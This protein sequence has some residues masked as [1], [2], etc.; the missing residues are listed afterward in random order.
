MKKQFAVLALTAAMMSASAASYASTIMLNWTLNDNGTNVTVGEL[1]TGGS[2]AILQINPTSATTFT[3]SE[4][5]T[6]SLVSTD[7]T[8]NLPTPVLGT[9]NL[10]GFG[11]FN[12]SA[13]V[14][15]GNL[16]ATIAGN[17]VMTIDIT[18]GSIASVNGIGAPG[19]STAVNVIGTP[20]SIAP[21]TFIDPY[22]GDLNTF[23]ASGG[24]ILNFDTGN[25]TSALGLSN[26]TKTNL[27]TMYC[28]GSLDPNC[29]TTVVAAANAGNQGLLWLNTSTQAG[30]RV[31]EPATL[32]LTGLGLLGLGGL[33]RRKNAK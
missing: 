21:N 7:Y 11:T 20:T 22:Y 5:G 32:A 2:A 17:P 15:G 16:T 19:N 10:S 28:T 18:S 24:Y 12:S 27:A 4:L 6:V 14:T 33:R 29:V 3:W 1:L 25:A 26:A 9:F 8:N 13:I 30:F 23:L 31:P